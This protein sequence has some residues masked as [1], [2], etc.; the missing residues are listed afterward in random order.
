MI[1]MVVWEAV[2]F[3][4]MFRISRNVLEDPPVCCSSAPAMQLA[5]SLTSVCASSDF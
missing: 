1:C 2:A 4:G 5:R 3:N